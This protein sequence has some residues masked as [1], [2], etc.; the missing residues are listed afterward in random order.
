[1]TL[2]ACNPEQDREQIRRVWRE[3]G[4]ANDDDY[5]ACD[6]AIDACHTFVGELNG[7]VECA[8]MSNAGDISYLDTIMP[9]ALIAGVTTSHVGRRQGLATRLTAHA[10]ATEA[11][12]G[13]VVGGLGAFEA[14][15]YD[16]LGFGTGAYDQFVDFD[17]QAIMLPAGV[18][19]RPPKRWTDADFEITH[20]AR[21][22]RRRGHAS[23]NFD[24][25][26]FI[27]SENLYRKGSLT[28]GYTDNADGSISHCLCF[29]NRGG[30]D[31]G[32]YRVWWMSYQTRE[33]LLELFAIM[34]NLGDQI[35][36]LQI[37]EPIGIMLQDI[38]P[39]PFRAAGIT[40]RSEHPY[41]MWMMAW[42]QMRILDVERAMAGTHL[43][44]PA[45]SPVRFNLELTDPIT[46]Y[47]DASAPWTGVAGRYVVSIGAD[48][49][50]TVGADSALP[51]LR[52]SIGTF[53]RI[54]L[55]VCPASGLAVFNDVEAPESL[56]RELDAAFRL[57]RPNPDWEF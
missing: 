46:K 53:T 50:A 55:G 26:R 27:Q 13:A 30:N 41:R 20:A 56:L 28:L 35:R 52:T 6:L 12:A 7:E 44:W 42:W 33:Q 51:T 11:A 37:S 10:L 54:W 43:P 16:R 23:C 29:A 4:W 39:Q 1:M 25:P 9:F 45:S 18:R 21:V 14:G 38:I 17:P 22:R 47:L 8:V 36:I 3:C 31:I 32:P 49:S 57:P 15:F 40:K 2:R 24:D 5:K 48:S 34:R 19:A